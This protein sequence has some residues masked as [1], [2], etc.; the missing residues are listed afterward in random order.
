MSKIIFEF[1]KNLFKLSLKFKYRFQFLADFITIKNRGGKTLGY[2]AQ[3]GVKILIVDN[4]VTRTIPKDR[5]ISMVFHNYALY[6]HMTIGENIKFTLE[7][8]GYNKSEINEKVEWAST[9]LKIS[10]FIKSTKM[11]LSLNTL[12]VF[13]LS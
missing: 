4:D 11:E 5:N 3:S 6:P 8:R 9:L 13:I 1:Y 7:S 2:D 10:D 12:F